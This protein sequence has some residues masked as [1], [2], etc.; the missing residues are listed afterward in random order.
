MKK[1]LKTMINAT[2]DMSLAINGAFTLNVN[3]INKQGINV[4]LSTDKEITE[5][6]FSIVYTQP[7]DKALF[8]SRE[9]PSTSVD[10][11]IKEIPAAMAD[12]M[13]EMSNKL[14]KD[15]QNGYLLGEPKEV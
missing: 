1:E 4:S 11:L 5:R 14:V 8:V 3:C 12:I 7:H 6:R 13:T 10:M 15:F 9:L 2:Q